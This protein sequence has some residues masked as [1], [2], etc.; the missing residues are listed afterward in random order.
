MKKSINHSQSRNK[1]RYVNSCTDNV[2]NRSR[3]RGSYSKGN[4]NKE[5]G[6]LCKKEQILGNSNDSSW[7]GEG[8]NEN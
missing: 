3:N 1:N 2:S 6:G 8:R 5:N 4:D 7:E